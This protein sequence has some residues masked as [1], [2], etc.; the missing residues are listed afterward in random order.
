M[1]RPGFAV[2]DEGAGEFAGKH[3]DSVEAG[4]LAVIC[5]IDRTLGMGVHGCERS[6]RA[7][8][9]CDANGGESWTRWFNACNE[10]QHV[11]DGMCCPGVRVGTGIAGDFRPSAEVQWEQFAPGV[12][13][14]EIF[15]G[16]T[17]TVHGSSKVEAEII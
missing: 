2:E 3:D 14:A 4:V 6:Q 8:V 11:V 10:R 13:R 9:G 7:E 16:E 12:E 15:V 5:H 17:G 1:E